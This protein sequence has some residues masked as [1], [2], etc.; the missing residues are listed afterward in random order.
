VK[1]PWGVPRAIHLDHP[2]IRKPTILKPHSDSSPWIPLLGWSSLAGCAIVGAWVF[3]FVPP[4]AIMGFSQ[5]IL[6]LHLPSV[7]SAYLA[8]FVVFYCSIGY[9]WKRTEVFDLVARASAEVGV[10]FSG[11]V[12]VTGAIWGRPTWGTYWVWDARLTT[13]LI[14]FLIYLGY[15]LLRAF[16]GPGE[17]QA[18]LAAVLGIIGFLDIPL[19]HVSVQWWRTLHQPSTMFKVGES[20]APEPSMPTEFLLP[21]MLALVVG[22]L[23]YAF[24]LTYRLRVAVGEEALARRLAER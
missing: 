7:L 15:V 5:K 18:R 2:S 10:L 13:S 4:D 6:Y 12:L 21:L 20:G 8:F 17:Q 1:D 11:L 19:I 9:L 14:L 23:V 16:A 3:G 22:V 24:F